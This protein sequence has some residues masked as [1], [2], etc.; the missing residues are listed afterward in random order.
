MGALGPGGMG[1][2]VFLDFD[3]TVKEYEERCFATTF[4]LTLRK[5]HFELQRKK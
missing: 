2:G 3:A 1:G 4:L 5:G